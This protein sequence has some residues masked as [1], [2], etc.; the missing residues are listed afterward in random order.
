MKSKLEIL[1]ATF[2]G[3]KPEDIP[4]QDCLRIEENKDSLIAT[5]SDGLG[6]ACKSQIGAQI[7]CD[8]VV[9][10]FKANKKI[11][12]EKISES[13]LSEWKRRIATKP[14]ENQAYSTT[15]SFVIVLKNE[16][17]VIVGKVGDVFVA[18]KIDNEL[19]SAKGFDKDFLNET[20]ALGTK[21]QKYSIEI[22]DYKEIV[23]FL[24]AS[25]GIGDEF[26]P[27]RM[28]ALFDYFKN[29]YQQINKKRR[30]YIFKEEIKSV[31]CEKN[32][33]DKTIIFGWTKSNTI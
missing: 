31:F 8:T 2:K 13:I 3:I 28:S 1:S 17:K 26:L 15:N 30:H 7:A 29:K 6:S 33:D 21:N 19:I 24:I 11:K 23:D 9:S 10:Y 32:N 18:L 16:K 25:D 22:F 27:E 20:E 4:N 12:A 14:P 5:I